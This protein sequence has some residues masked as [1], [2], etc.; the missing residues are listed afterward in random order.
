MP[1]ERDEFAGLL[2]NSWGPVRASVKLDRGGV[3]HPLCVLIRCPTDES[4]GS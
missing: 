3:G 1:N 2:R 4:D